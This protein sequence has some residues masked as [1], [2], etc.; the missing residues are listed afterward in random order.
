MIYSSVSRENFF[1]CGPVNE[2]KSRQL[3]VISRG[4]LQLA[5]R[6]NSLAH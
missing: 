4:N 5:E 2:M 3:F 6:L 1:F